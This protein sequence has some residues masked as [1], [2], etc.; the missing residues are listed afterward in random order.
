M[1]PLPVLT[2]T[3]FVDCFRN[4]DP[5]TNPL[6]FLHHPLFS[7]FFGTRVCYC[8]ASASV[9]PTRRHA[10]AMVVSQ[11]T[12]PRQ[13]IEWRGRGKWSGGW[14]RRQCAPP[15]RQQQQHKQQPPEEEQHLH[16]PPGGQHTRSATAA[17]G[18]ASATVIAP[19]TFW[20]SLASVVVDHTACYTAAAT[21]AVATAA[22]LPSI[23]AATACAPLAY[24]PPSH[25][26]PCAAVSTRL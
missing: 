20:W 8:V 19:P 1:R 24:A 3:T 9:S 22:V 17:G 10:R 16:G 18:A 21:S 2:L 4:C 25:A 14:C 12:R 11:Q 15:Q 6:P 5:P 26:P 7:L 13:R 23:P